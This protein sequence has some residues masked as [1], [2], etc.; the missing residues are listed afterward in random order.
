ML[1]TVRMDYLDPNTGKDFH[2]HVT[3]LDMPVA[4]AD[5][6]SSEGEYLF[7]RSQPFD[8]EGKRNRVAHVKIDRQ[9]ADDSHL[10]APNGFL[11]DDWWHRSFWVYGRSVH[12]G[13]GYGRSGHV[14]PSGKIMVL[15]KDH[16]YI[17]G[18][19]Q[20]FWRWT[21]PL[22]YRLF[23]VNRKN[24]KGPAKAPPAKGKKRAPRA[25][26]WAPV[27][28]VDIPILV[29]AMAKA[30]D[31]LFVAGPA[32][33]VDEPRA[34]RPTPDIKAKLRE[35]AEL[36]TGKDGSIL[37]AVSAEDGSKKDEVKLDVLPVFDGMVAA[38]GRIF[39]STVDG[40]VVCLG[41]ADQ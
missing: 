24:P 17:Y 22:E 36:F 32:D 28:S 12:G 25:Q 13:P 3:M 35:Q 6:L 26:G 7:M 5:I 30:G 4:S 40:R 15:D 18:R 34:L 9:W 20:K 8:L 23:T 11:D 33:I 10:F 38:H 16:V 14:A 37:R 2:T 19:Q 31:I 29:R 1:S 27:W 39:M 41:G 21:T